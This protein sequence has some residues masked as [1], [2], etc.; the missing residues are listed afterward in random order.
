MVRPSQDLEGDREALGGAVRD[1]QAA[2]TRAQAW[3]RLERERAAASDDPVLHVRAAEDHEREA[4]DHGQR[5]RDAHADLEREERRGARTLR[6]EETLFEALT[7]AGPDPALDRLTQFASR[8]LGTTVSLVSLVGPSSQVFPGQAGLA[9]AGLEGVRDTPL[10]L[11]ICRHVVERDAPLV[12]S[13]AAADDLLGGHPAVTDVG[14]AAYAGVPL[15]T[16]GAPVGALCAMELHAREWSAADVQLL[17]DF[18]HTA[19]AVLEARYAGRLAVQIAERE[20]RASRVLQQSLMPDDLPLVPRVQLAAAYRPAEHLVGGDWYDAFRLPGDRVAFALGDVVGHGLQAAAAAAQL[21]NVLLSHLLQD[22]SPAVVL[23]R[24]ND[25][26]AVREDVAFSSTVVGILDPATGELE[27]AAAGH[28]PAVLCAGGRATVDAAADN[29]L[30]A[31]RPAS[32]PL[33]SRRLK[34]HPGDALVLYT[35]GL[36]E[37]RPASQ[38]EARLERLRRIC[39]RPWA[40][41][42]ALVDK[43]L[44]EL[45]P[46]PADDDVALFV[47]RLGEPE[48]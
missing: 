22:A 19:E 13:D 27:W 21:R 31:V 26:A 37:E 4:A 38:T 45:R 9:D 39:E 5:A 2:A 35:D 48:A 44:A 43:V 14:I 6:P 46:G 10:E 47:V 36:V 30:L 8:M 11:S 23:A 25:L 40:T 18:A 3:G 12:V 33:S 32:T 1:E 29:P 24:L 17:D 42:Q 28:P 7:A 41:P 16:Q 20:R 34:M 15:H